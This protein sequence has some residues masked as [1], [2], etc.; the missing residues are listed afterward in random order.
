MSDLSIY[1]VSPRDGLQNS[2]FEMSVDEKVYLVE[3]L[4]HAGLDEMEVASFVNPKYVPQMAGSKEVFSQTKHL[5]DFG[6]LIP[7][8]RG[9]DDAKSLGVSKFN[10]FF[11][12]CEEFNRRNLN[13]SFDE[14]YLELESM[15]EE[16]DQ[17]DVRVYVSCA[18]GSP[19]SGL[20]D[21]HKLRDVVE[22]ASHLSDEVVLCDTVGTCHPTLMLRTLE[23]VK[24]VDATLALH[25]H[26]NKNGSKIMSNVEAAV[27][28]GVT[29]FD[30]SVAGLGGCPFIPGSGKNLSTNE[31]IK[32]ANNNNYETG[33]EIDSLEEITQLLN[34][35]K[36][37]VIV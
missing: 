37:E 27:R 10:V 35:K 31:F 13:R 34:R 29:K 18:F 9:F 3:S 5:G 15:L 16:V 24:D 23:L 4:F 11:S 21:E 8:Q 6:T 22:K 20:P 36:M 33:I 14:K 12:T 17:S 1:E 30:A 7:N 32:W 25:L 19:F 28:W 26:E 2:S